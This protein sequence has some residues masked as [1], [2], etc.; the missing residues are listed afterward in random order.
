G[1]RI[2]DAGYWE[3]NAGTRPTDGDDPRESLTCASCFLLPAACLLDFALL[4]ISLLRF[5]FFF[6]GTIAL[7]RPMA[8]QVFEGG[9]VRSSFSR[10]TSEDLRG[11]N[12]EQ[13]YGTLKGKASR[14]IALTP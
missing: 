1:S 2:L 13:I 7:Y 4:C 11:A 12:C 3:W 14:A 8:A 10:V 9:R 5:W 6:G